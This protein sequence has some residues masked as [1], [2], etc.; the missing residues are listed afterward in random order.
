MSHHPFSLPASHPSP[1]DEAVDVVGK[2]H[3]EAG[4]HGKIGE[5]VGRSDGPKHD[6]HHIVCTVAESVVGAAQIGE[7][8]GTEAGG[9]GER[10][11]PQTGGA[12]G[13]KDEV[14]NK[15]D[16]QRERHHLQPLA[17]SHMGYLYLGR[18]FERMA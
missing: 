17:G 11:H 9:H 1:I 7:I 13:A 18:T 10:A 12:Q 16:E 5:I 15:G 3:N 8:R 14:E 6:E 2:K 4:H